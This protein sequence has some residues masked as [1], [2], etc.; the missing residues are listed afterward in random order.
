MIRPVLCA[1]A[2]MIARRRCAFTAV[3][4]LVVVG[5]LVLVLS[6]LVPYLIRSRESARRL[7]C[8]N[9]LYVI[10]KAMEYYADRNGF[11]FPSVRYDPAT[12]PSGYTAFTGADDSDP[13]A[14]SSAVQ[15]NDVTASLWLLVRG[16]YVSPSAFICPGTDDYPDHLRNSRGFPVKPS[17]RGN[18]RSA[19]NLSYSYASP[20]SNAAGYRNILKTDNLTWGFALLADKNP[21]VDPDGADVTG[22]S[23]TAVPMEMAKANSRN[24]GR[25]GQNVVYYGQVSFERTPY[26]GLDHDNIYTVS[27]P[28]T[29][30]VPLLTVP[31]AGPSLHAPVAPPNGFFGSSFSPATDRDS[32]L[33]P[34]DSD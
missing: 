29:Q 18:F 8:S 26:C 30:P 19:R 5:V 22:P 25:G 31:V 13:F 27:A 12:R 3:E 24:H 14:D 10:F 1:R 23:F 21:G 2:A 34:A 17:L 28:A 6:I 7:T 20:F 32:Y 16:E 11:Q 4:C 15:P 33:V 9:N